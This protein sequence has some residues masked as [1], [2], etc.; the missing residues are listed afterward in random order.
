MY[1]KIE[2]KECEAYKKLHE[3]RTKEHQMAK[4]NIDAINERVGLDW[5][6]YLG[7]SGQQQFGRVTTY[8]G[9]KFKE[10]EKVDLKI[11]KQHSEHKDIFVPNKKTKLGREMA[12]FLLNG[13]KGHYFSIVFDCLGIE[14]PMR[15]FT[16]PYVEIC[17]DVIV[18]YLDEKTEL[19]DEN[20]IEITT[21]D[22]KLL[23]A[24]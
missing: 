11:W 6:T 16:F 14:H 10:P 17:G 20:I 9:F 15:R 19:T 3:M 2:N 24:S 5:E 22:A 4:D 21:K 1:Y 8:E 12:E 23:L 13:L 18:L 7:Y